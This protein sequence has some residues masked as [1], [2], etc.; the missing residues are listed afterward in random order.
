MKPGDHRALP[1][2][3]LYVIVPQ[4][5]SRLVGVPKFFSETW[6][7]QGGGCALK[8]ESTSLCTRPSPA[9][10]LQMAGWQLSWLLPQPGLNGCLSQGRVG[11]RACRQWLLLSRT[12][13][14]SPSNRQGFLPGSL[15]ELPLPSMG[16]MV[17][18]GR[19]IAV[20]LPS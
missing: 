19:N 6:R 5:R 18:P 16:C 3:P 9:L 7:C 2:S 15:Q 1:H 14:P 17:V 12:R 8:P 13:P 20:L 11:D 10:P 4:S